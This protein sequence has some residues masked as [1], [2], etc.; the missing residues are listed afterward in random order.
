L[1]NYDF[2]IE[3]DMGNYTIETAREKQMEACVKSISYAQN[4]LG[5]GLQI[6]AVV[7]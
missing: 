2:E 5:V 4:I 6:P 3:W 1:Q 7:S